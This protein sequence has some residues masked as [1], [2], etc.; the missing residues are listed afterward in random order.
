MDLVPEMLAPN[1][2][3]F[4]LE[5]NNAV[6]PAAFGT[7]LREIERIARLKKH[8]GPDAEIRL[9][10]IGTG[11]VWGK[12]KIGLTV[13]AALAEVSNFAVDIHDRMAQQND[14]LA[15]AV[16]VMAIDDSVVS[17][18][19]VTKDKVF[20]MK[21]RDMPAIKAVEHQREYPKSRGPRLPA[22]DVSPSAGT[23]FV[24]DGSFGSGRGINDDGTWT[25]E[26]PFKQVEAEQ[27]EG[28]VSPTRKRFPG[29]YKLGMG[30][31]SGV[32]VVPDSFVHDFNAGAVRL[33]V[34]IDGAEQRAMVSGEALVDKNRSSNMSAE[35]LLALARRYAPE[36]ARIVAAKVAN[37]D[38]PANG[39]VLVTSVDL[40]SESPSSPPAFVIPRLIWMKA[41]MRLKHTTSCRPHGP[42]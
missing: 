5:T 19:I 1:E 4:S 7:F 8:F 39:V 2:F 6:S 9:V 22:P 27:A 25:D 42:S 40:T 21:T 41:V 10:E 17:F 12:I 30:R 16:A 31:P 34:E 3:A 23:V 18:K 26:G 29:D 20:E 35:A 15:Q 11:S 38:V 32:A 24:E 36:I 33:R 37:G 13:A 28:L 14:K